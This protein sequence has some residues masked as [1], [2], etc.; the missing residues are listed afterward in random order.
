MV[1]LDIQI[2]IITINYNGL[3]DI[4]ELIDTLPLEDQSIE[5]IVVD[6]ASKEDEATLIEQCYSQVIVIRSK[7]N[8]G[9]AGG[10]NLGI[11]AARG[12]YLFFINNDTLLRPQ[13]SDLR[14]LINRL[15]SSPKIGAVCPKIRFAWG[16]YPIQFAGYTPLS[17]ITMRNQAIGCGE[18]D[19][20]QYDI[21]RTTPYAHGAAMMVKREAIKN[22]G[23]MPECYFLYYEE[24]DWSLMMR[25]A[26]YNIWY[27]PAMTVYHKESQTTGQ[28][29]P[30]RTYYITRNRLLFVK[31]NN[32]NASRYLS[33]L[34]LICMVACRDLLKYTLQRRFDLVKAVNRGI[35]DFIN[36]QFS[37]LNSQFSI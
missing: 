2:S 6:N 11:K 29:S 26:G 16:N 21:A 1:Q 9:F 20:G 32:P 27:E 13:T 10:N 31:R 5:V 25:R 17:K 28:Q 30:M 34:Y 33:Y 7:E 12:K 3:K 36:S 35:C 18:Q 4:C 19:K 24:L 15:E 37:I 14:L 22:A 23:M 8:L